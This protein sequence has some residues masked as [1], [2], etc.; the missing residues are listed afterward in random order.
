MELMK[1][2]F[3]NQSFKKFSQLSTYCRACWLLAISL[4]DFDL[5]NTNEEPIKKLHKIGFPVSLEDWTMNPVVLCKDFS[6][7]KCNL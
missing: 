2:L 7:K 3:I 4:I 5:N 6:S 1:N